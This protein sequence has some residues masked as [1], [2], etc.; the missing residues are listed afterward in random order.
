MDVGDCDLND[1]EPV[2]TPGEL[3]TYARQQY[4]SVNDEFFSDEELYKHIWAAQETLSKE[5]LIE[6]TYN[7]TT[8][9]GQQEYTY[10]TNA[11][12]IRRITYDGKRLQRVDFREDDQQTGFDADTTSTGVPTTYVI[13]D[14]VIRL[15]PIPSDALTLQIFSY[16]RPQE[17]SS[18]ST[19]DVPEE[20]HLG[21]VDF[22]L[23]R[24]ASKDQNFQSAAYYK[25]QWDDTLARARQWARKRK[26][27]DSFNVVRDEEAEYSPWRD[28][29]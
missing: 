20:F 26:L 23:W 5:S 27:G 2:M 8:V 4:N 28:V 11:V 1:M 17:V 12:A 29:Y 24:M 14:R 9:A 3:A 16:D 21:M 13:F 6:N 18:T 7:T 22:L 10:P 15:R 19:L 25:A